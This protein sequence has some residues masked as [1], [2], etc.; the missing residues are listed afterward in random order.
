M[1]KVIYD[2]LKEFSEVLHHDA[3]PNCAY[4]AGRILT[5][6]YPNPG[7]NVTVPEGEKNH[8]FKTE[9]VVMDPLAIRQSESLELV[10]ETPLTFKLKAG[11]STQIPTGI[12][13]N[14]REHKIP[15]TSDTAGEIYQGLELIKPPKAKD[16]SSYFLQETSDV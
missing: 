2:K 7:F 3:K 15:V 9:T 16:L 10:S 6:V 4:L 12:L 8:R 14:N 5:T 1:S 11:T 13:T